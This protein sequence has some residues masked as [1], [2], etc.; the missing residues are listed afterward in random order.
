MT[1]M[2]SDNAARTPAFGENSPLELSIPAAVKTGTTTDYRDNWTVGYTR[3]LVAGVWAGNSDGH[4]MKN[5]SGVTGAAPIWHNF[6][7]AL[8]ARPELVESL[9]APANA[10][11]WRFERPAGITE[12]MDCPPGAACR[13]GGE[14]Y[15]DAWLDATGDAGPLADSVVRAPAAPVV[16]QEGDEVRLAGFCELD[17]AAER[18]MLRLPA[19]YGPPT[20]AERLPRT[21]SLAGVVSEIG[22]EAAHSGLA[23][24][25]GATSRPCLD[26]AERRVR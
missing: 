16:V 5:A 3:Y 25:A 8:L 9:G 10:E 18:T 21:D 4:P 23:L 7:E 11:A 24:D 22:D 17:G 14:F 6:M 13:S 19:G 20:A 2:L 15:R 1:D 26:S 12:L